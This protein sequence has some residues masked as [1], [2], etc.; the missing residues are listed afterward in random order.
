MPGDHTSIKTCCDFIWLAGRGDVGQFV[1]LMSSLKINEMRK[2][3]NFLCHN[4]ALIIFCM[5]SVDVSAKERPHY[6]QFF[7]MGI[8][9]LISSICG[10]VS[11]VLIQNAILAG[12]VD[13]LP[14]SSS[15]N[16]VLFWA[17]GS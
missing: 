13:R 16:G 10:E 11:R 9:N 14:R 2:Q 3:T 5:H 17:S 6:L 15:F 7:H 8:P 12:Q 4:V 1:M